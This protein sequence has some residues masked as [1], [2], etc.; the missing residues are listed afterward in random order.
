[1][2]VQATE[3]VDRKNVDGGIRCQ[4]DNIVISAENTRVQSKKQGKSLCIMDDL[5]FDKVITS[6]YINKL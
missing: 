5:T 2:I 3:Q 1:M 4:A 6:H